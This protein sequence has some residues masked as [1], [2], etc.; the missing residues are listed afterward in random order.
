VAGER[1][2]FV[3]D[4]DEIRHFLAEVL[5]SAGYDVLT[6]AD[7]A[8]GFTLARDLRPD[9]LI[10]DYLMPGMT[11]L[12]ML[13]ALRGEGLQCPFILIT[14]EGSEA[15]AVEALRLGVNDY[16]IKPFEPD[17]LL[18]AAARVLREHW[19]RQI[20]DHI[21]QQLLAANRQLEQRLH[22][23]DTL[24]QLGQRVS[25]TLDLQPVLDHVVQAAKAITRAESGILL[26]AED[27]SQDLYLYTAT[28]ALS[29]R[30][31]ARRVLV[32]DSAAGEVMR[33]RTPLVLTDVR[34][35]APGTDF[36]FRDL[37]YVPLLM[38]GRAIG[39]LGVVN[40]QVSAGFEPGTLQLLSVLGDFAAIAITNAQSY[41]AAVHER[42]T[43]DTVLTDTED[44]II[45]V[46]TQGRVLLCNPAACRTFDLDRDAVIGQRLDDITDHDGLR[47]LFAKEARASRLRITELA[48]AGGK[49]TLNAHLTIVEGVGKIAVMQDI[50]H[51]KELD[52]IKSEFV[53]TVSHDLRSPL[54]AILG[55]LELLRRS[56]PFNSNQED[57]ARRI[58]N[59]VQ[60]ITTLINDLLEL[61]KIEAGFDQDRELAALGPI[62]ESAVSE[63]QHEWEAK[64]QA[65]GVALAGD[66]P[67]VLGHPLRLRQLVSNLLENAIKYTPNGGQVSLSLESNGDFLVLRVSDSGIGIPQQDQ[68]YIFD[69]FYRTEQ[70]IDEYKGTGLGLSIVKSIVEQHQGRIWVDS[71]VGKGSTFTVM[72]PAYTNHR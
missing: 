52:R 60:S 64:Q 18:E 22:D 32:S 16:L 19:T 1:V 62:I 37:A 29:D 23:L 42:D 68:P 34:A 48:V 28:E 56:G 58:V 41:A 30:A 21:P 59:S 43:L 38:Q 67:P 31:E 12:E 63:R 33:R 9:L 51:L 25:S 49:R 27:G 45:V 53:T 44:A 15:L 71:E 8:E 47:E 72:L 55:Y 3:E 6:G 14:A 35:S 2:L 11:G 69:K 54:T 26:L 57:F 61:G 65:L 66:L 10:A 7:G 13:A 4:A 20:T 39:V 36:F 46:D 40:Q 50:T 17:D 24:V 5:T 70:A